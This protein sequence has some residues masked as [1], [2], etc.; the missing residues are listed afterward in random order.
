MWEQGGGVDVGGVGGGGGLVTTVHVGG[1]GELNLM[2]L[3]N[4]HIELI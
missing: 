3:R 4:I 2:G 1:R